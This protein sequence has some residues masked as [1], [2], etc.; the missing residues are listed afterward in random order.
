MVYLLWISCSHINISLMSMFVKLETKCIARKAMQ[1]WQDIVDIVLPTCCLQ[2][3]GQ[4]YI[5]TGCV[6]NTEMCFEDFRNFTLWNSSL[7]GGTVENFWH[8]CT[9]TCLPVCNGT[10]ICFK[11]ES[12]TLVSVHINWPPLSMFLVL[13]AQICVLLVLSRKEL[14]EKIYTGAH[15]QSSSYKRLVKL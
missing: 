2:L 1:N 4:A 13:V 10:K 6:K 3:G 8:G 9:T 12:L 14:S 7:P 5:T 11:S 15:L